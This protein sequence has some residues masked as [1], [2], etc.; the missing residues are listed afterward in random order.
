MTHI[1][2]LKE[3]QERRKD[4]EAVL[5]ATLELDKIATEALAQLAIAEATNAD[6]LEALEDCM[7][8]LH[9][10]A[11]EQ[12]DAKWVNENGWKSTERLYRQAGE[13][14]QKAKG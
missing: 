2:I 1:E 14:I 3:M 8:L 4:L 13:A 11:M 5:R 12:P 9:T 7:A 6:L 10:V